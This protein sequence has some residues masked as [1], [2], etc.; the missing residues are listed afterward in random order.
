M[1][2]N[3][4]FLMSLLS[5]GLLLSAC[6]TPSSSNKK[7]A[8]KEKYSLNS[9]DSNGGNQQ[10]TFN[11][12]VAGFSFK[13]LDY[14]VVATLG[15]LDQDEIDRAAE[16]KT[17][18]TESLI[19]FGNDL[20]YVWTMGEAQ[21]IEGTFTQTGTNVKILGLRMYSG[22]TLVQEATPEQAEQEA[23]NMVLDGETLD[24]VM[25]GGGSGH[26][27]NGEMEYAYRY[28]YHI[29]HTLVKQI[30]IFTV[31]KNRLSKR[32]FIYLK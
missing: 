14:Y 1:R 10:A 5:A 11:G 13:F 32:F 25:G 18:Y 6:N 21:R 3:K 17:M 16:R 27:V 4:V 20:N 23:L 26:E 8:D 30:K 28:E 15:E 12:Q 29:K 2:F 31:T 22:G 24:G 7:D 9:G 19:V